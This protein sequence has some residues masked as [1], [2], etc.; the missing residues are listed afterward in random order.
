[1]GDNN[2]R[3][4]DLYNQIVNTSLTEDSPLANQPSDLKLPLKRHQLSMI[5]AMKQK[6][7]D[8]LKGFEINNEIHHSQFAILGDKVGAGKTL[9][10][11]GHIAAMKN[12]TIPMY[13]RINGSSKMAFWST[14]P[15]HT[16]ECS[17][18]TLIIVPHTLFHQWKQAIVK[19]TK[20]S[21][22]E[23]KNVRTLEDPQFY[24]LIRARD[25]T[26]MTNTTLRYYMASNPRNSLLWQRIVFDELDTIQIPS[27]IEMPLANFYWLV[28]ASWANYLHH[29][30]Y[31]F[32][33][34]EYLTQHAHRYNP[35]VV[36]VLLNE[37]A[38]VG[39]FYQRYD[40]KSSY[41]FAP[42]ISKH[43]NRTH[44]ILR[45]SL[46]YLNS[47][48]ES[49]TIE[50]R[51]IICETPA[52]YR[53][54]ANFVSAEIQDLLNAGDTQGAL[55]RLGVAGSTQSSLISAVCET[56]EKELDR[57]KKLLVYK[58]SVEYAT[59]AAK[60]QAL[61]HLRE[62]IQS[63]ET[64][65]Q[66]LKERITNAANEICA[67]CFEEPKVP[68]FVL[69]CN[70][71][72]C[73]QCIVNWLQR[74]S[75]CALCRSTINTGSL[76]KLTEV[77]EKR[78]VIVIPKKPTKREALLQILKETPNGRI[79]VFNRYDNPFIEL[80]SELEELG[81]RVA[82]VKGNRDVV[83]KTLE[84]FESGKIQILLMNSTQAGVGMD[85]KSATHVI[86]MHTMR[87][88]EE[89]QILGRAL[90]LGRTEP[91]TMI[92]LLFQEEQARS[93]F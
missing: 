63:V 21:F 66:N 17:G 52:S 64:Q 30:Q 10:M 15:I 24:T 16:S 81:F 29:G 6:E 60:E 77:E 13:H 68:T 51:D 93:T 46:A 27:T 86:L 56:R 2:S 57:L 11:L 41:F 40:I 75:T 38:L 14:K 48:W 65:I 92:R 19:Q 83:S 20:L 74:A 53:I 78:N 85:L 70:R 25:V 31:S 54:L 50:T 71:V 43:L 18:N 28:T 59:P 1:M 22:F 58:E 45:N 69:C 35:E 4:L 8:C 3:L 87:R 90:R 26:L 72:F 32:M 55:E 76:R 42:F 62:K 34:Q 5:A 37:C 73:G 12:E 61:Q 84:Q 89:K 49:P 47:S 80:E 67:I 91:L 9:M 44:L 33:S 23:V 39:N 7:I 88:E 36:Q 79:L 82:S